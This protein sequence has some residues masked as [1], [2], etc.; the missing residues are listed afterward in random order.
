MPPVRPGRYAFSEDFASVPGSEVS[1][2]TSDGIDFSRAGESFGTAERTSF[3]DSF[4]RRISLHQLR[5]KAR[6]ADEARSFQRISL[7]GRVARDRN[8]VDDS[9]VKDW[10]QSARLHRA[11]VASMARSGSV[12][13][14][15][16]SGCAS[17]LGRVFFREKGEV[18]GGEEKRAERPS[19][20]AEFFMEDRKVEDVHFISMLAYDEFMHSP[21]RPS[22]AAKVFSR[23]RRG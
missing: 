20:R 19:G 3:A 16:P 23:L 10:K 17:F 12:T 22:T 6:V 8:D 2:R 5:P 1:R 9:I 7:R 14:E 4:K 18:R 21:N 15:N 11:A 13:S